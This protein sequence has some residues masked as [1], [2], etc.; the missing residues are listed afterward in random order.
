MRLFFSILLLFAIAVPSRAAETTNAIRSLTIRDCID[1]AL[2]ANL[3]IKLQR[4]NLPVA[5][6][7]VVQALSVFDPTLTG[8]ARYGDTATPY[9]TNSLLD[10]RQVAL[11]AGLAGK[12]ETGTGYSLDANFDHTSPAFLPYTGGPAM[13]L[14]QPL[15]KNFG[16]EPNLALIRVAR[17]Q[18]GI[19]EQ[20]FI[21]QVMTTI[22][23]VENAYYELIYA[24]ENHKAAVE[25]L[26]RAKQ[27]LTEDRKRVQI[28]T[29][30]PLDVVQAE[31]GVAGSVNAVIIAER[32]IKDNEN[33]LKR[34]ITQNVL[35]FASESLVPVNYPKF[36]AVE[37]NVTNHIRTALEK[38]PDYLAAKEE[39]ERRNILIKF[40]KNQ[41][42]PEVDLQGSVGVGG[43][44]R[45][46]GRYN[47]SI[48]DVSYPAWG[49]GVAVT[50]PLGNRSARA[51]YNIAR[52]QSDQQVIAMKILEQDIIVA[53]DNALRRVQSNLKSIDATE[54]AS[55]LAAES[56]KA[57]ETKLRAG[58]STSFLVLQ[59]QSVLA[60]A[61][62][63]EIRTRAD[64]AES[65]AALAQAEGR[66]LQ[67][68]TIVLDNK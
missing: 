12:F 63:A 49:I 53:V 10:T 37:P 24:I 38:R 11:N 8:G 42:L 67:R 48:G 61:K 33:T 54:A 65:L 41:L 5:D 27:L 45:T 56:L 34:L 16:T 22:T 47:D 28:G 14:T 60:A 32:T 26:D 62:S 30:S 13:T 59:A 23:A 44:G 3:D 31:S 43:Y 66:T 21:Q 6:W 17:K 29:L 9:A 68:H 4:V 35:E 64:Y 58:T 7:N 1:R 46:Y 18:R 19:A 20:Y 50:L 55:R 39:L 57:E 2:A 15:L 51:N 36:E 25:D 52:L 40:T